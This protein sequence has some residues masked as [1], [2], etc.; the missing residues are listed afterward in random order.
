M[1]RIIRGVTHAYFETGT[2]G[3][4]WALIEENVFGYEDLNVLDDGDHLMIY[5][6]GYDSEI[7]FSGFIKK[8]KLTGAR[9]RPFNPY[10][11]QQVALGMWVHWIQEGWHPDDW[12]RLFVEKEHR[13]ILLPKGK[14]RPL[15]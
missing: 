13:A 5:K 9:S 14:E 3:V 12:A 2:E 6:D 1:N 15:L 7:I 8:D 11:K 4:W 10:F